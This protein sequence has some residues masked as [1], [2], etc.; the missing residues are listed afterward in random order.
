MVVVMGSLGRL[1]DSTLDVLEGDGA[2]AG[3]NPRE[4]EVYLGSTVAV[5]RAGGRPAT[6]SL[7]RTK[8][9]ITN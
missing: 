1:E 3:G 9:T 4:G 6:G 5:A 2:V 7:K 8:N